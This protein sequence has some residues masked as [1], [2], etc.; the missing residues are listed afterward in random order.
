MRR[1]LTMSWPNATPAA[2]TSAF[3]MKTVNL[4]L[5]TLYLNEQL[6][7]PETHCIIHYSILD[8]LDESNVDDVMRKCHSSSKH[9]C[10][11]NENRTITAYFLIINSIFFTTAQLFLI[12][13]SVPLDESNIRDVLAK[14]HSSSKHKC[15]WNENSK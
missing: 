12:S 8:L 3:G 11:W 15:F 2:S 9:K 4:K 13:F 7:N 1:V 10:S 6:V 5:F 14:C